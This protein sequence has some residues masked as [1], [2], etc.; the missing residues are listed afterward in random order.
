MLFIDQ[1]LP[2]IIQAKE[3]HVRNV[4]CRI[5]KKLFG[6][7]CGTDGCFICNQAT[8]SI[9]IPDEL[10]D[11]LRDSNNLKRILQGS[12]DQLYDTAAQVWD[13]L[14]QQFSW[15]EYEDFL[16]AKNAKNPSQQQIQLTIKYQYNHELIRK[17]FDYDSWFKNGKDEP[18]YDAYQLSVNLNRYTCTYC[19]R[20]YTHTIKT[21]DDKKIMRP[22]FDHWFSHTRH[23]LLALSFYNL[24]PS[25]TLCNSSVKGFKQ[26]FIDLHLHP[27]LDKDC[28]DQIAFD[29]F[30]D[31]NSQKYEIQLI[32]KLG[33]D[34]SLKS[35]KD[36]FIKEIY[37]SHQ[38]ELA[39]IIKIKDAYSE[40]YISGMMHT[41]K[42]AG[43]S[44]EEVYRLAFGVEIN[45]ADFH[46]RPLSKFTKDILSKL[47][48]I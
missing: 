45:P 22:T 41:Y 33:A 1:D 7:K 29:Y 47:K 9:K 16:E 19:N 44:H 3:I 14:I 30:F 28:C 32:P 36:M 39:D 40:Q 25:C 31:E 6:T 43:L 34:R 35:Y 23:P 20:L 13:I 27:Y 48:I 8:H 12:P 38:S 5:Q 10:A 37:N 18:R 21:K 17:I 15:D 11:F 24:I 46:K 2:E 26:Y 4:I 42:E